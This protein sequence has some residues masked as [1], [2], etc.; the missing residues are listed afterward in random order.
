MTGGPDAGVDRTRNRNAANGALL[1]DIAVDIAHELRG[2]VQSIVV[3]LEVARLKIRKALVE[4]AAERLGV[5]EQEV[6]RM[7]RVADAFVSLLR[8]DDAVHRP[9]SLE[10][11]LAGLDPL[12]TVV[13]R[14]ARVHFE[15]PAFDSALLARVRSAPA[16]LGILRLL[17]DAIAA[18]GP[19]GRVDVATAATDGV[20]ELLIRIRGAK[21]H[22]ID[23]AA[24]GPCLAVAANAWLEDTDGT[25][26]VRAGSDA[27]DA[28]VSIRFARP[29]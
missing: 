18:A 17:V 6:M 13:A 7:H 25:A 10:S 15:R 11:I 1:G 21:G 29:A 5:I 19:D 26:G 12:A 14:S 27:G 4:E 3:N 24:L 16:T 9:V 8:P 2:P 20:A 28:T 23:A 22:A